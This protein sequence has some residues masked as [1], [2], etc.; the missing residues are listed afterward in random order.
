VIRFDQSK[1][2]RPSVRSVMRHR[3]SDSVLCD[4]NLKKMPRKRAGFT[5]IELLVSISLLGT[6]MVALYGAFFQISESSLKVRDQL[7]QRQELRLL[8]RMV[9]DDLQSA[10][11]MKNLALHNDV[12]VNYYH[13]GIFATAKPGP[14]N[15]SV[16]TI[17]FHAARP[18]R[19]H[20][21]VKAK[22]MD[23]ELHEVGYFME[24]DQLEGVWEFKRREDFYIDLEIDRGG[25]S[26]S[27]SD[28]LLGF[29]VEFLE[30]LIRSSGGELQEIWLKEWDT[31]E[32][33]CAPSPNSEQ[34]KQGLP[35]CLPLAIRVTLSQKLLSADE[36]ATDSIITESESINL[37]VSLQP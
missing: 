6:I 31:K 27:L 26:F 30:R 17:S 22:K 29:K 24:L 11:Y 34:G 13:T 4:I 2:D 15:E 23:P 7:A 8:L 16:S 10:Q 21:R 25:T 36:F 33:A 35:P 28:R 32:N 14:G 37:P 19:F 20:P 18:S 5:L 9:L 3:R 12:N 1:Y